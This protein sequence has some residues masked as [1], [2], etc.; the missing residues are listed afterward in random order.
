MWKRRVALVAAGLAA[1]TLLAELA[2]RL[3]GIGYPVFSRCDAERGWALRPGAE[4]RSTREGGARVSINADGLRDRPHAAS[5]PEG[6]VRIAVLGDSF[7]EA[8]EVELDETFWSVAESELRR[9]APWPA[10]EV[11]V[12]NFGVR[13]YGTAQELLTLRCCVARFEPDVVLLAL[14]T[15]ND[16]SENARQLDRS[17]TRYAR[18]Y[19]L[20]EDGELRLDAS[21]RDSW[22]FR[23]VRLLSP[24]VAHSR[25]LQLVARTH[26]A[27]LRKTGAGGLQDAPRLAAG[28]AWIGRGLGGDP[29]IYAAPATAAW[30]EAWSVTEALVARMAAE[31]E[32]I[33]ARF[34]VVT[35]TNPI[36]VHPDR[37]FREAFFAAAGA[38]DAFLPERRFRALGERTGFAV[39]TLA[40]EIRDVVD[41]EGLYVHGFE[42]RALGVGHWN[43]AGHRLAGERIA[44]WIAGWPR[45]PAGISPEPAPAPR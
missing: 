38:T 15:G 45:P 30:R 6:R 35:L 4:G 13:G 16:V 36:Q 33:G 20:L 28:A 1:G 27:V 24:A 43:A 11:E 3:A 29:E 42:N 23:A 26:H 37:D 12:L 21:F 10:S 39:L 40:P 18:P 31:T 14:F 44:R 17:S 22:R 34:A 7:S 5:K 25:L 32:A 2:L 8:Q 9:L 19:F 41:A